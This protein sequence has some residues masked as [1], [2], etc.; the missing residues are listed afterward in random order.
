MREEIA[1][2]SRTGPGDEELRRAKSYLVGG[3]SRSHQRSAARAA[4][5]A[6]GLAYGLRWKTLEEATGRIERVD[7]N[8]VREAARRFMSPN[9]EC[10][11][12]VSDSSLK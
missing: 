9:R 10:L 4:D 7:G 2:L 6:F 11:V 3:L 1:R 5:L 8:S 12:T